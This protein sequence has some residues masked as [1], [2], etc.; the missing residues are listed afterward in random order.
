MTQLKNIFHFISAVIVC[1]MMSSCESSDSTPEYL[2]DGKYD[3]WLFIG[4]GTSS[5]PEQDPHV[6]KKMETLLE[7]EY[8]V[9]NVGA[10]TSKS[11]ITPNIVYRKGY[12]YS[13]SRANNFE[14]YRVTDKGIETLASFPLLEVKDR[15]FAHAW[16]DNRTLLLMGSAGEQLQTNWVKIDVNSMRILDKG[17]LKLSELKEDEKYSSCGLLIYRWQD[18]KLLYNYRHEFKGG[19]NMKPDQHDY[20]FTATINPKTMELERIEKETR[21]DRPGSVSWGNTRHLHGFF[22]KKGDF[23]MLC[24]T[25]IKDAPSSTQ[26]YGHILRIKAGE[27]K[28]DPNYKIDMMNESKILSLH[29]MQGTKAIAYLQNPI[30]ATGKNNWKSTGDPAVFFWAVVDLETGEQHH[31]KEI[32]FSKGGTYTELIIIENGYAILGANDEIQTKFFRYDF[33]TGKVT[34]GGKLK[35]GYARRIV[36]LDE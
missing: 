7:G 9:R 16:L 6:I 25:V 33:A 11:A 29:P 15:R 24:N 22:D 5:R 35:K 10:E 18:N 32:P 36:K 4:K 14:K 21:V 28:P 20:F 3:L 12:Y 30:Y 34:P 19:H 17:A 23:Y 2:K 27:Y 8:D 26:Q 31:I 1:G 13:V